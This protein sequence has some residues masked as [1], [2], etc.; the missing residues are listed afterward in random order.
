MRQKLDLPDLYQDALLLLPD[1]IGGQAL[2]PVPQVCPV[3]LDEL[4]IGP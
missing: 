1:S 4:L 3:V 2:L